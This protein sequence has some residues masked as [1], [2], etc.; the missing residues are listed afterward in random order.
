VDISQKDRIDKLSV[1]GKTVV[2]V[3]IDKKAVGAIALG[4]IIREESK[5]AVRSDKGNGYQ[6]YN[7]YR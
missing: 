6:N 4:D 7:A 5:E 2:F 3:L 1:Q